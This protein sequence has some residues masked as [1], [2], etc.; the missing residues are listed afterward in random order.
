MIKLGCFDAGVSDSAC[1]SYL[2]LVEDLTRVPLASIAPSLDKVTLEKYVP[3]PAQP[4]SVAAVQGALKSL[5]F[6]SAGKVDGICGYRTQSAIRLF[7]EFSGKSDD[8]FVLLVKGL[9]F[10]FQGSTEPGA[11]NDPSGCPFL[12]QGQHDYHFGWHQKTYL[13]L[14][15]QSTV[16]VVRSKGD[17][18]LD[19]VDLNNPLESNA[20]INIHW[21]GKGL[22]GDLNH[23][24][25]GCQVISGSVYINAGGT[26]VDCRK[27][28]AVTPKEALTDPA[29]T[30]GAYNVLLDLV[31]ALSSERSST[32][33]Y[34][35]LTEPDLDLSPPLGQGLAEAR[36][37]VVALV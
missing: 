13:A 27:F 12:V 19:E 29:R 21:G 14:R 31:T 18:R 7:Q 4:M 11:T 28:A 17:I 20:T 16:L 25:E 36:K 9:V 22:A 15:P 2:K 1:Q 5:G 32:V 24:S 30:R 35:L 3:Q 8:V 6:Y 34:M 26:L 10:K 33:Q 23:W 37:A